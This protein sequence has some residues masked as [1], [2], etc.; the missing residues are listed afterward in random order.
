MV[1]PWAVFGVAFVLILL[2]EPVVA[3]VW[4]VLALMGGIPT[5]DGNILFAALLVIFASLV[6]GNRAC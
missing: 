4:S 6:K 1:G 3:L 2:S 5:G